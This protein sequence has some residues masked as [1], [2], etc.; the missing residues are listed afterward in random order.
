MDDT[1]SEALARLEA[2][3]GY[4]FRERALLVEALTH[5]SHLNEAPGGSR[6]NQRL[7]FFGDAVLG[8]LVS[9]ALFQQFPDKREGELTRLR[10]QLV[11]EANLARLAGEAGLGSCLL[12][13]RG[14]ERSG[15]RE[16]RSVLA[17]AYEALVAAVYLDGG[18][19][20]ARRIVAGLVAETLDTLTAEG[21]RDFKTALQEA[22]QAGGGATPSYRLTGTSGPDHARQFTVTVLVA[23]I[24]LGEGTGRTKKEAEQAA[25]RQG[26]AALHKS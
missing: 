4:R 3:L 17:D 26:L 5:R 6:D 21:W 13:G 10:A 7:E 23:G 14:E 16:K 15:G 18:L 9:Q 11:D 2:K 12:L 1:T 19:D 8:F 20:A 25:A 22:V 24:P